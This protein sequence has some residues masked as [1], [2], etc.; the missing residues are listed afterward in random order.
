[1]DAED[2]LRLRVRRLFAMLCDYRPTHSE[3]DTL[4]YIWLQAKELD[5][6]VNGRRDDSDV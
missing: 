5:E 2:E 1:M 6:L 3:H 4:Y